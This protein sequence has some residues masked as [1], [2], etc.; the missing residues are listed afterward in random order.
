MEEVQK[1]DCLY[2]KY[3]RDYKN[4]FKKYNCWV[5]IATKFEMTPEDAEKKFRNIRTAYGRFLKKR[6]SMPSG[7][8][9][10][11]V[12]PTPREFENLEWLSSLISHRETTS[13][14]NISIEQNEQKLTKTEQESDVDDRNSL[15]SADDTFD[16]EVEVQKGDSLDEEQAVDFDI[17]DERETLSVSSQEKESKGKQHQDKQEESSSKTIKRCTSKKQEHTTTAASA[18]EKAWVGTKKRTNKQSLDLTLLKAAE[19]VAET[20]KKLRLKAEIP[21][22]ANPDVEDEDTLFCKSLAKRMKRLPLQTKAYIR[23]Q[24]EQ[25]MYQTEFNVQSEG[26]Y[27]RRLQYHSDGYFSSSLNRPLPTNFADQIMHASS[28]ITDGISY[29]NS[30][31]SQ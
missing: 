2:N 4:R 16:V 25:M 6:K 13:N 18:Q 5:Q 30:S 21:V 17:D 31:A 20:S 11:A 24:I 23:V 27:E 3:N 28:P 10:D 1:Y 8:G 9:R 19:Q 12:P 15:C 22:K 14:L 7:S 29:A 26:T